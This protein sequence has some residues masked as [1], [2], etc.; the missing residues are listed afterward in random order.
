MSAVKAASGH[1]SVALTAGHGFVL[2]GFEPECQF[3]PIPQ[4]KFVVDH[5]KVVF[6][7]MLRRA[8]DVSYFAVFESLGDELNDL[9][10]AGAGYAG[11]VETARW[12]GR[13]RT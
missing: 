5:A 1:G 13:T 11:S 2:A 9:L 10:L 6:Y 4:P 8:D 12:D 7:D 3:D